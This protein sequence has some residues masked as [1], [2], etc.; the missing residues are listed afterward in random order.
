MLFALFALFAQSRID[1]RR[2]GWMQQMRLFDSQLSRSARSWSSAG[3]P[4]E[5]GEMG[6][7][8]SSF[9]V[10]VRGLEPGAP[11]QFGIWSCPQKR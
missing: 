3:K 10:A 11:K 9:P 2:V 8:F 1:E 7:D 4:M 6:G 5:S